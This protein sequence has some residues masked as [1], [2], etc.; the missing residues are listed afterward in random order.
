MKL[1]QYIWKT[2]IL[3]VWNSKVA[4]FAM[5]ILVTCWSYNQPMKTFIQSVDYPVSW[6]VFPF[7]MAAFGFLIIFWFGIIYVNSDAPFM[8]HENMYQMLRV[9][10]RRWAAGQIGGIFVRSFLLVIFTAIATILPLLPHIEMTSQWGKLLRTVAMTNVMEAYDFKYMIYYEIFNQFTPLQLMAVTI[11]VCTLICTFLGILMF[12]LSIYVNKVCSIAGAS[13]LAILMF[14]VVNVNPAKR[15]LAACLVPTI[16][17]E[18]AKMATTEVG[19]LWMPSIPYMLC[20]LLAG[21]GIMSIL[22][23]WKSKTM[24]FH[25]EKEDI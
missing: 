2:T 16:W 6:C 13:A 4:T 5:V 12:F 24:E 25:W 8:Q 11:L 1:L 19:M 22:I 21:I 3:K 7:F 18:I 14:L 10:R 15:H 23:L 9:G 17:V 20:F